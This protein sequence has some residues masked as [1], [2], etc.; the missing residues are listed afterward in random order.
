MIDLYSDTVTRPTAPMRQAMASAQ[1]G[2][3]QLLEDLTTNLLQNR[4]AQ[5]LGK[6]DALFL[7]SGTMCNEVAI[8]AHTQPSDAVLCDRLCHIQRS[9]FGGPALLSGV[10]TEPI[11]GANGIFTS[12]QLMQTLSCFGGYGALPRLVC[13]EQ[14]HNYGGGTIWPLDQLRDVCKTAHD[15]GLLTHMDGARLFNAC[16]ATG[17]PASEYAASCDSVWIDLSKGLGCPIGGVL[18]GTSEFITR[19]RRFKHLFGGALRQSGIVAAAGVYA[20][21][22]HID[23]LGDDHANA[24]LLAQGLNTIPRIKVE[25]P[26]PQTNIVFFTA[27]GLSIEEFHAKTRSAGLR[28][29]TSTQRIRA[30]THLDVTAVQIKQAVELVRQLVS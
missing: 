10:T 5:L 12:Q 8:K 1:V 28:F 27:E 16:V 21:D 25:N 26:N 11:D 13:V 6:Q 14:T 30:V 7:P 4:I 22:H 15:R 23:R 20:L 3:E 19:C 24:R 17:I 9:E 29:S 18:A 2:D